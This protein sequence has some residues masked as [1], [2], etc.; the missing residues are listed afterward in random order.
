M[1]SLEEDARFAEILDECCRRVGIGES[2]ERCLSDYPMEYREELT[3]L[4]PMAGRVGVL[5]RDPSP[6]FQARLEK[7]L[8]AT[9]DI[10]HRSQRTGFSARVSRLFA[11]IP[12]ARTA[13]IALVVLIVLGVGG[14][15]VDQAAAG[16][17][18]DSPLYQLK[19]IREQVQ[20]ALAR[21]PEAQVELHAKQIAQRGAELN[22]AVQSGKPPR[23]VDVLVTRVETSTNQMVEQ[24]LVARTRGNLLPA[25]RAGTAIRGIVRRL[26]T[27]IPEA[28]PE[29]RPPLERLRGF[30]QQQER[31]LLPG[32]G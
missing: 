5:A 7:K 12:L 20:L 15:G 10:I 30:F 6:E 3:R 25:R 24:A 16:S 17:L 26:D 19:T 14:F 4:V 2:L 31:R 11:A 18:P 32:G 27:I 1:M 9:A 21:A 13:V 8:L 29:L 28:K 23:V 22:Q